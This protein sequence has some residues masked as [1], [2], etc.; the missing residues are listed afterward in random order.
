MDLTLVTWNAD[1]LEVTFFAKCNASETHRKV[2][3]HLNIPSGDN[4]LSTMKIKHSAD[5][6][7]KGHLEMINTN[8]NNIRKLGRQQCNKG[9]HCI[10][11]ARWSKVKVKYHKQ[12]TTGLVG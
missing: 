8:Y 1:T 12:A 3:Q 11:N 2:E 4:Q 7:N 10:T 6:S 9:S 5:I